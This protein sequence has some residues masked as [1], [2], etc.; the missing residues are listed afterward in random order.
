MESFAMHVMSQGEST[1]FLINLAADAIKSQGNLLK[2]GK[3]LWC[4]RVENNGASIAPGHEEGD[5]VGDKPTPSFQ[6]KKKSGEVGEK[7]KKK[8]KHQEYKTQQKGRDVVEERKKVEPRSNQPPASAWTR[9]FS[10]ARTRPSETHSPR[11]K[12]TLLKS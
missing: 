6:L 1:L 7:S 5:W 10:P 4:Q 8:K 2:A 12:Q 11:I 9:P 3:T